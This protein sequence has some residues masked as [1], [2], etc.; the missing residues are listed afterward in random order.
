MNPASPGPAS[1]PLAPR[2]TPAG[3]VTLRVDGRELVVPAHRTVA[4]AIMSEGDRS[5]WRT[6]RRAG[7]PR[8]LFCGIGVCYD[9]LATVDG[10]PTVRTCLVAVRDGMTVE[11][12][13]T[14][15]DGDD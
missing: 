6:T 15:G 2:T 4:A 1:V 3:T 13:L 7:A 14:Q 9:C 11:T 10:K 5:G 8:G 12:D